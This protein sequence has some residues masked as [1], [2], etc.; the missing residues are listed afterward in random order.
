MRENDT[1]HPLV[2]NQVRT[3]DRDIKGNI[4]I[5]TYAGITVVNSSL[6]DCYHLS[7]KEQVSWSLKHSSVYA[8]FRDRQ[9]GMWVGTYYGGLSYFNP[10]TEDYT[11]YGISPDDPESLDGFLFG[12]MAEDT[13]G[14]LYIAT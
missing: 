4:W 6:R 5:G 2:N 13:K 8:I 1:A 12:K 11:F 3:I 10:N 14:N 7:H 9:G